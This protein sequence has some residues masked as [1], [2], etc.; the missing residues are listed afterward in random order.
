M[1]GEEKRSEHRALGHSDDQRVGDQEE[2]AEME[3]ASPEMGVDITL[4]LCKLIV[5]VTD[6]DKL[7]LNRDNGKT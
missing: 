4:V 6:L 5:E 3:K 7:W 2:S 1:N